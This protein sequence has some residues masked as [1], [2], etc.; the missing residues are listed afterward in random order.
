MCGCNV[1]ALVWCWLVLVR[2]L[3]LMLMLV[4]IIVK[5]W[6]AAWLAG[7]VPVSIV[8]H[9]LEWLLWLTAFR[10]LECQCLLYTSTCVYV[11]VCV[12]LHK[13]FPRIFP[14]PPYLS[15]P[16]TQTYSKKFVPRWLYS[17][18]AWQKENSILSYY[19]GIHF[20]GYS[21]ADKNILVNAMGKVSRV[22]WR[23]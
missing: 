1:D 10:P 9:T 8:C 4:G 13:N 22:K 23:T 19:F 16:M 21:L 6:L 2:V 15:L 20:G 14:I 12:S 5:C 11:S 18:C 7:V 17:A 3:V